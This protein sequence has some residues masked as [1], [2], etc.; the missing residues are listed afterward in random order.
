MGCGKPNST[1]H[2]HGVFRKSDTRVADGTNEPLLEVAQSGAVVDNR[3]IGNIV[4]KGVDGE[5]TAESI[6]LRCP[7]DVVPENHSILVLDVAGR[8][9]IGAC[10]FR[11]RVV[12]RDSGPAERGYFQDFVLKMEMGQPETAAYETAV[13]KEPLDLAGCG[14]RGY[15][16][17]LGGSPQEQVADTSPYQVG[18]EAVVHGVGRACA[19]HSGSP[20]F[21]ICGVPSGE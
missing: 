13:A 1:E 16:E 12:G 10:L 4:G 17:V 6:L 3:K 20:A 8:T 7:E 19:G 18:D 5:V 21:V 11:V 14:V 9:V 2:S 15:V